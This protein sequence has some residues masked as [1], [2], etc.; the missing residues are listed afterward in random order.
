M[1]IRSVLLWHLVF[2]LRLLVLPTRDEY[3]ATDLAAGLKARRQRTLIP[4]KNGLRSDFIDLGC[5]KRCP[6]FATSGVSQLCVLAQLLQKID[7]LGH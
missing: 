1:I 2:L 4:G 3:E 5:R 7:D 6:Y